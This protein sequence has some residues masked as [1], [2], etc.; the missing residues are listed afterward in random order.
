MEALAII[1]AA[2]ATQAHA[3]SAMPNAPVQPPPVPRPSRTEPLR[4]TTAG[5]LHRLADLVEPRTVR[6]GQPAIR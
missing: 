2:N 5:A 1:L 4:R 6:A 3:L